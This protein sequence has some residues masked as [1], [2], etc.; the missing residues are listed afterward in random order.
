MFTGKPIVWWYK[1][2]IHDGLNPSKEQLLAWVIILISVLAT[3]LSL[4]MLIYPQTIFYTNCF[5]TILHQWNYCDLKSKNINATGTIHL[6]HVGKDCSLTEEN[7][8]K[9]G[10]TVNVNV[11]QNSVGMPTCRKYF[12]LLLWF[13]KTNV[14]LFLGISIICW[15]DNIVSIATNFDWMHPLKNAKQLSREV[16]KKL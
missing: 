15:N 16:K 2:W 14:I 9:K 1:L 7:K 12:A 5:L 13:C 10:G 4:L 3:Q 8:M 11:W 6:N